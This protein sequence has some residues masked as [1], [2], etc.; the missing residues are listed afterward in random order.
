MV[1]HHGEKWSQEGDSSVILAKHL[2]LLPLIE[3]KEKKHICIGL[4]RVG[5]IHDFSFKHM[6]FVHYIG[7]LN[8]AMVL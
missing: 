3:M 1:S 5:R 6:A 8:G 7:H 2:L 4:R